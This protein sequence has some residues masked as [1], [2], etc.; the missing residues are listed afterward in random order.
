M[1]VESTAYRLFILAFFILLVSPWSLAKPHSPLIEKR[2][3]QLRQVQERLR[4]AKKR[5]HE[6][7]L[8]ELD[9][10]HQ[11]HESQIN[12]HRATDNL[13]RYS[14]ELRRTELSLVFTKRKLRAAE[15]LF[16]D[17][18]LLI[19]DRLQ[20][21]YKNGKVPLVDFLF[22]A[23]TYSSLLDRIYYLGLIINQDIALARDIEAQ[24]DH[25]AI[26][27]SILNHQYQEVHGLREKVKGEYN[28]FSNITN[29]RENL[30]GNVREERKTY[31]R[32]VVELQEISAALEREM[33]DLIRR[34]QARLRTTH[35][36]TGFT[37]ALLWPVNTHYITSPFGW[38]MHPIFGRQ[39]FHTGVDIGAGR[40]SPIHAAADG[41]VIYSGWYGGYG[42]AV[43]IDH[44]NGLSTLYAHCSALYVHQGQS[45]QRG[46]TIAA[47]GSTGNANGPHL[48]FEVRENGT[49]VD[50]M[51][52]F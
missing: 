36:F 11:L 7:N 26:Q 12:L 24:K 45:V 47:V 17:Q 48:H 46:E 4:E 10:S 3:E 32:H 2:K 31:A 5:L 38:R 30:L 43:V 35:H 1:K 23:Q 27:K 8:R 41:V 37:G 52:K 42:Q 39:L 9:L 49:A 40:G 50:P 6:A 22:G 21:V 44:G 18:K 29:Q 25:I 20:S 51:G 14:V 16:N 13:N 28:V 19:G 15:E 33:Q 34:E